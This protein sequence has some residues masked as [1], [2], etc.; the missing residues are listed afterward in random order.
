MITLEDTDAAV[1]RCEQHLERAATD[2]ASLKAKVLA[3]EISAPDTAA[4]L[5]RHS[6][7]LSLGHYQLSCV[8]IHEAPSVRATASLLKRNLSQCALFVANAGTMLRIAGTNW[9]KST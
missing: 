4:E 8:A 7:R 1:K 2:E 6:R 9:T 3:T 5:V